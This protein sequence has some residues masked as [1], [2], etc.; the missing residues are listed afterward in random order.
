MTNRVAYVA[1]AMVGVF[2]LAGC[3]PDAGEPADLVLTGG[4]VVT[5]DASLPE[6]EAVAVRG[7][8]IAA[9]GSAE[10]IAEWIGADTEV[11]ELD[12]R[13]A[14][15]GFIEGH[16]HYMRLGS[17]TLELNLS[18][19]SSWDEIVALVGAAAEEAEPGE[20]ITGHGWHQERWTP[21]PEPNIDGLPFHASLSAASP[22]NPVILS[23]AS[24]HASF[25]NE[26]AMRLSGIDGNT[27]DPAGGQIVRD[28]SGNAIGAF[29]ET[30]SSL[31]APAREGAS[32]PEPRR[33]ALLAQEEAFGNGI[34]SFQD[35]GSGFGTLD[36]WRS[37]VDDGSLKIRLYAMIRAD[38]DELA[39]RMA[40]Y[41][42][43]GYG[44]HGLTVRALKVSIDG[45]LGSHGAWL[46]EPYDDLPTSTGLN[47][48]PP[49]EIREKARL[50]L[51]HD[52]QLNVHA[53]GDRGNRETLDIFEEAYASADGEDLRWRVEHAQHLH[54]D[55]IS[56]FGAL[57]VIASMQ[58]VHA[59]SDGP[60]VEP[61]LGARRTEEG[62]YV[63]RR[64]MDSGAV[65]M[66]GTDAPVEDVS[67][68]A[69]YY[70]S[71]SRVMADGERFT[72]E[73]RM[74]RME[75]LES[76]TIN[77]AFGAFEEDI[78]GSLTPGKLAD[79]VVLSQD[80]LTVDEALIPETSVEL[81]IV[82]GEVVYERPARNR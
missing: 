62:A 27:P 23:H 65:I 9:V 12:G 80:I 58:G 63:W 57:G 25:A 51:Q 19:A 56:R 71:V 14:M 31:L 54:P 77:A 82:G 53:I 67:P 45:A 39:A 50:A 34:T 5:V 40:D 17:S 64:L 21:R 11:I 2:F 22:D 16:A 4:K 28:A 38:N 29:R 47:T 37:M 1:L 13:L 30:A 79:I 41:R 42:M 74:S 69:N 36:L 76:Y 8:R 20:L 26:H 35:A 15:P 43:V 75:A 46:L 7:G 52:Y 73:Q 3:G 70:S 18:D 60:W 33:V 78:K 55:E 24:G 49:E 72:P 61:K 44:D 81:T 66:N 32:A 68:I 59:T 48:V 10:E 6:G